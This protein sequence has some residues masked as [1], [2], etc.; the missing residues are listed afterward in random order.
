MDDRELID[1]LNKNANGLRIELETDAVYRVIG[2][3]FRWGGTFY[4]TKFTDFRV[5]LKQ[6]IQE[7]E[8]ARGNTE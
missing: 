5:A 2:W 6:C 4:S 1:W 3:Q 8:A 7:I